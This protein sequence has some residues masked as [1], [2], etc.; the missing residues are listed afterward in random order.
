MGFNA[1]N[2]GAQEYGDQWRQGR[3][4]FHSAVHQGVVSKYQSVQIRSAREL[5]KQLQKNSDDL[6]ATVRKCVL[7][8][9]DYSAWQLKYLTRNVGSTIIDMVY[10]IDS[11][12]NEYFIHIADEAM[13][14]FGLAVVPGTYLVD[15]IPAREHYNNAAHAIKVRLTC[16]QFALSLVGSPVHRSRRPQSAF[17][18]SR[19]R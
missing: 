11:D 9:Y 13:D 4:L 10:G 16:A 14:L 19:G 12:R 6:H 8:S 3:R 1:W 17:V 2:F 5:L 7:S 18:L 15:L